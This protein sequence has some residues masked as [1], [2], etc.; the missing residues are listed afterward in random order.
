MRPALVSACL[1]GLSTRY[2]GSSRAAKN[3]LPS[4]VIPVPVCPEILGGLPTPRPRSIIVGG[5]GPEVLDV[6]AR[7]L[8]ALGADVTENFIRGAEAALEIARLTGA[9]EAYLKERSPSCDAQRGVAAV[10]LA[11]RGIRVYH[12][13]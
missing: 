3:F 8:D 13:D 9:Q 10:L 11:R 4:D 7:V 5:T 2:D 12:V 1:L 6:E